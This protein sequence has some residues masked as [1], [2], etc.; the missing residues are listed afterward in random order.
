M[1]IKSFIICRKNFTTMQE[2][3]CYSTRKRKK[4]QIKLKH[5]L[6]KSSAEYL[7]S[8]LNDSNSDIPSF[9]Q[10]ET[11]YLLDDPYKETIKEKYNENNE[12]FNHFLS[13]NTE[14]NQS[15]EGQHQDIFENNQNNPIT[16]KKSNL[17]NDEKAKSPLLIN[18]N[19]KFK[20]RITINENS[21]LLRGRMSMLA[22]LKL[23]PG[24]NENINTLF[25]YDFEE[26]ANLNNYF[27]HNNKD[28][29]ISNIKVKSIELGQK[30]ISREKKKKSKNKIS[31]Q[32]L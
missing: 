4:S 15:Q 19:A 17:K 18:T 31:S 20:K 25:L 10:S 29:I 14:I 24:L 9:I 13:N 6:I 8:N 22:N 28:L 32:I 27:S 16:P 7:A 30:S 12:N 3:N 23:D 1:P 5:L 11:N 21:T 2:R 26:G